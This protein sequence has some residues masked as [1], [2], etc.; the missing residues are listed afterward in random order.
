[1]KIQIYGTGC[2]K[3]TKLAENTQTA[4]GKL[5]IEADIEKI[6]DINAITDAGVMMTPALGIDGKVVSSGKVLSPD[7]ILKLLQGGQTEAEGKPC[8]CCCET[9]TESAVD[10]GCCSETGKKGNG[11]KIMTVLLLL[12]VVGSI[13]AMVVR[14]IRPSQNPAAATEAETRTPASRDTVTVY[15]FH[16]NQRCYTCNKIEELTKQAVENKFSDQIASGKIILRAINVEMPEN[17]H[18]IKDFELA[19]RSVVMQKGN[20]YE[21]FD[22]VWTLV[23]EPE[24][25]TEYIQKGV[26]EMLNANE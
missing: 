20:Q 21:K 14:E 7:D 25:F 3:C 8:S 2:A 23:R 10:G 13:A 17:E 26:A 12:L 11:K 9:K 24:K 15:Y 19:T 6:T 5:G 18:F 22:Q 16:G 4:V 1:M